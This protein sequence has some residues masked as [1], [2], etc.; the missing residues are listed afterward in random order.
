M[1][2]EEFA[3]RLEFPIWQRRWVVGSPDGILLRAIAKTSECTIHF[4]VSSQGQNGAASYF[5]SGTSHSV[6][7]AITKLHVI[8]FLFSLLFLEGWSNTDGI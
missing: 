7:S 1:S 6:I 3:A 8:Y 2:K 5:L 4:P